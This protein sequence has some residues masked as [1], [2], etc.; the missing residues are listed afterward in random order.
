MGY[1]DDMMGL[2]M[3]DGGMGSM[4]SGAQI[5]ESLMAGGAGGI[6]ILA[7]SAVLQRVP[8]PTTWEP[9]TTSRVK[10]LLA[11][12]VSLVGGRMLHDRNPQAAYGFM[13]GVGGLAI[14][15]LLASFAP[16]TLS[17][18][19]SGGG[20]SSADLAALESA[21]VSNSPSWRAG[22]GMSGPTVTDRQLASTGTTSEELADYDRYMGASGAYAPSF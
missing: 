17:T 4:L 8:F 18:S 10:N 20:L 11:L 9:A 6:G 21:A 15:Q 2:A 19:L 22:A 13:G 16:D 3:Y 14:A 5:K 12:G 1:S 7:T